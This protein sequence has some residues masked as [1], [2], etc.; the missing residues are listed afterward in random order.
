M[1]THIGN[2]KIIQ[3]AVPQ[4][5]GKADEADGKFDQIFAEGDH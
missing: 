2:L 5:D 4:H 3:S 1:N